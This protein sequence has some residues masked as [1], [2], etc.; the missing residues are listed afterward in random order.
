[1]SDPNKYN[2][3]ITFDNFSRTPEVTIRVPKSYVPLLQAAPD[4]LAACKEFLA[5]WEDCDGYDTAANSVVMAKAA[6]AKAEGR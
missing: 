5:E 6:I 1:M 2:N 3:L 4:L